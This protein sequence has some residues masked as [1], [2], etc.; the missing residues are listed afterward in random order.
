[1]IA[2]LNAENHGAVAFSGD[3]SYAERRQIADKFMANQI[4]I[5]VTTDVLMK[6]A[7]GSSNVVMVVNFEQPIGQ[8]RAINRKHYF[9]RAGRAGTFGLLLCLLINIL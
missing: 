8:Q 2:R 6:T 4:K 5:L 3:L 9:L 7:F 1:M